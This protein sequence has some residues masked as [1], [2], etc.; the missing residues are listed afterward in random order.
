[1]R[2]AATISAIVS[3]RS[4]GDQLPPPVL[5]SPR[6]R[7]HERLIPNR[8]GGRDRPGVRIRQLGVLDVHA[9]IEPPPLAVELD[10]QHLTR[11]RIGQRAVLLV[12]EDP[13]WPSRSEEHT[14]ELQS[15]HDLVCRLLLEKKKKK[16]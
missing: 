6:L 7:V 16:S 12:L 15:H 5:R 11:Q 1:M 13:L 4:R 10:A 8:Q 14:S 3:S 9:D 2:R